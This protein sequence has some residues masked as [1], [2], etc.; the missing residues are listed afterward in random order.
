MIASF[1]P[2][3]LEERRIEEGG[4]AGEGDGRSSGEGMYV[5]TNDLFNLHEVHVDEGK[6]N[7]LYI[8]S[9]NINE[10]R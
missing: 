2:E 10:T 6:D 8:V 4:K 3:A 7:P 1:P 5:L 9:E